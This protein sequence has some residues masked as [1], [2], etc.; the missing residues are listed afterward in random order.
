MTVLPLRVK[1]IDGDWK[2]VDKNG[3]VEAE[4]YEKKEQAQE[5]CEGLTRTYEAY[6]QYLL[7]TPESEKKNVSTTTEPLTV[8]RSAAIRLFVALGLKTADKWQKPRM[9]EK[10]SKLLEDFEVDQKLADPEAQATFTQVSEAIVSNREI[11][12]VADRDAD[13]RPQVQSATEDGPKVCTEPEKPIGVIEK[14]VNADNAAKVEAKPA[15]PEELEDEP[16]APKPARRLSTFQPAVKAAKENGP[17]LP[18]VK[19][20]TTTL[21]YLV[22]LIFKKH[23][24]EKGVTDE[25]IAEL[26][27]MSGG[28]GTAESSLVW[29][30]STLRGFTSDAS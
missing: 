3:D 29:A 9:Q 23:G 14:A 18:R 7:W 25:M 12:L 6:P 26:K 22:G 28:S 21:P 8:T 20:K 10:I 5:D 2:V 24:L 16:V 4:G 27:E 19:L 17:V 1:R 13:G 11:Q 15:E 30:W